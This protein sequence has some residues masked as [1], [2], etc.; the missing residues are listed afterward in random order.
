MEQLPVRYIRVVGV[1]LITPHLVRITFGGDA[2]VDLRYEEPDQQVKLYFP[3]PG[4]A[5]PRLPAADVDFL[6]WYE[7]YG[8]IPEPERPWMRSYTLRWHDQR[9]HTIDI[10]FV[11]HDDAGP[12]TR[13][14]QSA[15]PGD[16]LGMFGPSS[17]FAR[18]VPISASIAAADWL[19]LA[20]DETA[21]PA[22]GTLIESLPAGARAV[23]YVE[24]RDRAEEQRF[25]TRDEV[26]VH[27]LHRGDTPAGD[28][29][30]LI[31]AVRGAEFPPGAVFAWLAGE[32]G[33]VR[34]LRRELVGERGVD[35]RSIEF[36]GYWRRKLS[37]DDAPTEQD[38]ADAQELMALAQD[39][40]APPS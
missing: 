14:A 1:R 31:D 2:L 28:S 6:R 23:A 8:A 27:W 33:T 18:P 25:D 22:I 39:L 40:Q 34:E 32:A 7:A 15:K 30:L 26:T 17:T 13:W 5:V 38:L 12:A 21:L 11:L 37:Q 36:S 29:G 20:G 16:T 10:D 35:R 9:R 19:L 4:H 24:V 3:R